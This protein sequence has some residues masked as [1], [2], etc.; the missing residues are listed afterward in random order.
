[1]RRSTSRLESLLCACAAVLLAATFSA[2]AEEIVTVSGRKGETQPYL[3]MH[4]A[5]QPK[6]VAVMFPGGEGLLKLRNEGGS[7]KFSQANNF[8]VRTRGMFRDTEVAVA[9]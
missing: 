8:L 6:A 9:I 5:P 2:G 1:M 4:N 7:V 3:L